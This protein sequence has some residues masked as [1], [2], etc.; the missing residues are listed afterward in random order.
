MCFNCGSKIHARRPYRHQAGGS[1]GRRNPAA[2]HAYGQSGPCTSQWGS[3]SNDQQCYLRAD[4]TR[5]RSAAQPRRR[6]ITSAIVW[7]GTP[8]PAARSSTSGSTSRHRSTQRQLAL[9]IL[10]SL[11]CR[12]SGSGSRRR[13]EDRAPRS[14]DLPLGRQPRRENARPDQRLR[15]R[16][17]RHRHTDREGR[18]RH[19]EPRRRH[20]DHLRR[21]R[22]PLPGLVRR[23]PLPHVRPH[24]PQAEHRSPRWES[25]GQRDLRL[26]GRLDRRRRGRVHPVPDHVDR[27][28]PHQRGPGLELTLGPRGRR[29]RT[30]THD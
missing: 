28:C 9:D 24:V 19:V 29:S 7:T 12:R 10:A 22:N 4:R 23:R 16:G 3:W 14:A 26:A 11:S 15:H 6:A 2:A 17:K 13:K 8:S 20:N 25:P 21:R 18:P 1:G 30:N 27:P 5:R